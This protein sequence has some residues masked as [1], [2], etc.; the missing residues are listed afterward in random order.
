MIR[1][2]NDLILKTAP[3]HSV[4]NM[5]PN[6]MHNLIN[7]PTLVVWSGASDTTFFQDKHVNWAFRALHDALHVKTGLDF[8]PVQEIELGRI[9]ANQYDGL[10]ADLVYCEVA[11]QSEYY[12]KNGLFVPN[13]VEFTKIELKRM[14]WKIC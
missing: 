10:M 9:Q 14:G 5:A 13:Q 2:I 3:R 6:S 12:L 4:S 1:E 8:T 7:Q 11:L